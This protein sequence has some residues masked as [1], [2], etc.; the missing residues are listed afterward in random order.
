MPTCS[1]KP[2][3]QQRTESKNKAIKPKQAC[4][5]AGFRFFV[6]KRTKRNAL[7]ERNKSNKNRKNSDFKVF[8]FLCS[9]FFL[10]LFRI[11]LTN[12]K[13]EFI[14]YFRCRFSRR[15]LLRPDGRQILVVWLKPR[16]W[17]RRIMCR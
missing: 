3:K 1:A 2:A 13:E 11:Y 10:T 17:W 15:W 8:V 4:K 7:A 16:R 6:K 5:Q 14:Y 9:Y 12:L